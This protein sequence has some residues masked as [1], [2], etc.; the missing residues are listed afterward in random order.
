MVCISDKMSGS[1]VLVSNSQNAKESLHMDVEY[2][3]KSGF[4]YGVKLV[5]GAYLEQE[6]EGASLKGVPDPVWSCKA[7][8][9][10]C[11]DECVEY[12]MT[13]INRLKIN[14]MVATHNKESVKRAVE[15]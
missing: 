8:T 5:R 12:I 2:S 6:R 14:M 1:A 4:A 3:K 11:Y 15:L 13:C 9:H 10:K 7:E